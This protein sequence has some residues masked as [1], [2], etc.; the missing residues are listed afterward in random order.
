MKGLEFARASTAKTLG[1]SEGSI[2]CST[3]IAGS[4]DLGGCREVFACSGLQPSRFFAL[5]S[6]RAMAIT[7]G[8]A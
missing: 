4:L 6:R 3:I 7:S 2:R 8:N 5:P 1:R